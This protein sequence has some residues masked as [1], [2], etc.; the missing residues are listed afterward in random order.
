MVIE[1]QSLPLIATVVAMLSTVAVFVGLYYLLGSRVDVSTRLGAYLGPIKRDDAS[2]RAFHQAR[3]RESAVTRS[4]STSL[5][6]DLARADLKLTV[7]EYVFLHFVT[8]LVCF[9]LGFLFTHQ[10]ATALP[11]AV[12][13]L[14]LPRLY[15]GRRQQQ[16]LNAFNSQ[17]ADTMMLIANSLRSGYSLLQSFEVVSREAP[18]PTSVEFLRVVRE[19]GL[20]LTPEEALMN[21]V[22]RLNSE[23]LE[24]MVTAINVQHEVGGNLARILDSIS[25]TIRQ[26]VRVKGEIRSLTSQQRLSGYIISLLPVAVSGILFLMSPS[27][28]MQLFSFKTLICVPVIALPIIAG[29][30][31]VVGFLVM[32]KVVAIE[33]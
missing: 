18:A 26:R 30:M 9:T 24:L 32:R 11:L 8:A 29:V 33:V 6:R 28:M 1:S 16:R 31:I 4:L 2:P 25:D 3:R 5:A 13:G 23:D 22:R 21:M 17:L 12:F 7:S 20:G 10:G 27:Y 19:V 14:F 15:V